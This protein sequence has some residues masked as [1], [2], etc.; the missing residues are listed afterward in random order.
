MYV[1]DVLAV[2]EN[3]NQEIKMAATISKIFK[4][5]GMKATKYASNSSEVLATIP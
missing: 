3:V 1:D 5:M 4:D 2:V